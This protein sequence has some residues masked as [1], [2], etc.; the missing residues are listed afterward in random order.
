MFWVCVIHVLGMLHAPWYSN[1]GGFMR[2]E[3]NRAEGRL[4]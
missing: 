3:K 4:R 1:M 2:S